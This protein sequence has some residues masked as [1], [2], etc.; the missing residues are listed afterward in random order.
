MADGR[1]ASGAS[2]RR[3]ASFS[4]RHIGARC[5]KIRET[6]SPVRVA[7]HPLLPISL[8]ANELFQPR[9]S[10]RGFF[11]ALVAA[12]GGLSKRCGGLLCGC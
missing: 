8:A 4:S 10:P 12:L 9:V 3:V 6:P 7:S 5:P 2:S 11:F 1:E